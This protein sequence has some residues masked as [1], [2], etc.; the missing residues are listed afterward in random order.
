MGPQELA[1]FQEVNDA[2]VKKQGAQLAQIAQKRRKQVEVH[3]KKDNTV[4]GARSDAKAKVKK[5]QH[6]TMAPRISKAVDQ[7]RFPLNKNPAATAPAF[8]PAPTIPETAPRARLFTR[9]L[10]GR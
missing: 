4:K 9:A 8:P 5:E 2:I 7:S 6:V 3:Q 10:R 1:L